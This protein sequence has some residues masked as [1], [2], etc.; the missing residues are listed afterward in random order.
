MLHFVNFETSFRLQHCRTHLNSWST[1]VIN[2]NNKTIYKFLFC[3]PGRPKRNRE[4]DRTYSPSPERPKSPETRHKKKK[5]DK[6]K[7]KDK[8]KDKEKEKE[9]DKEKDKDN[10]KVKDKTLAPSSK[11]F[12]TIDSSLYFKY[13]C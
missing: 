3:Y 6:E 5:K 8:D 10:T 1:F 12:Q 7:T 11:F 9:K 4:E 13:C 2:D